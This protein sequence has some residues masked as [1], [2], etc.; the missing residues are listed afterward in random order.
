M[1]TRSSTRKR[2]CPHCSDEFGARTL[3]YHIKSCTQNPLSDNYGV[4]ETDDKRQKSPSPIKKKEKAQSCPNCN[5][6]FYPDRMKL[7]LKHC[8]PPKD[9]EPIV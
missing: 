3:A 1:T 5:L 9:E 4:K 6:A 2:T 7:H 8:Q